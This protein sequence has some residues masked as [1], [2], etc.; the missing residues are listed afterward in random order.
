M[1]YVL[2]YVMDLNNDEG[3]VYISET[4]FTKC[5]VNATIMTSQKVAKKDYVY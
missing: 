5:N 2:S 4:H 1:L 3:Y